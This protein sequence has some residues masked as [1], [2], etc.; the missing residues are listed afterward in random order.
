MATESLP[1]VSLEASMLAE[2]KRESSAVALSKEEKSG[3]KEQRSLWKP[4]ITVA[5]DSALENG[6]KKKEREF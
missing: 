1:D 6:K 4:Q 5:F 2:T 3:R